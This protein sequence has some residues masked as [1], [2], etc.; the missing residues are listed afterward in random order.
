MEFD[1]IFRR[2]NTECV[3]WDEYAGQYPDLKK[4]TELLPMWVADMDFKCPQPVIDAVVERAK[5]GIYG[6][7]ATKTDDFCKAICSWTKRRYD[8]SAEPEW[9]VYTPGVIPAYTAAIQAFTNPGDGVVILQPVY[10]PFADSIRTNGREVIVSE[11]IA[12]EERYTIDFEDLEG[13][14]AL[15]KVK[16]M[17]LCNPHN[18][19]GR[20]WSKEELQRIGEACLKN[21]VLLV[22]DEIHADLIM[23]GYKQTS[24]AALSEEIRSNSIV[25]LSPSKTFNMAG[26]QVAYSLIPNPVLRADF[27]RQLTRN[28]MNG[29]NY[30]GSAALKAAYTKCDDWLDEVIN[31]IEGNIDYMQ[32]YIMENIPNIKMYR[33]EGTYL[34]WV[35]F[36]QTGLSEEEF[37]DIMLHKA[38]IA[39]DFGTW[40]GLGGNLHARFCVAC[41]RVILEDC[42]KR[43]KEAFA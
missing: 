29:I 12:G 23:K 33:P 8:V 24:A 32:N 26:L 38:R 10:Y 20:V 37:Q 1:Q 40:F 16:M 42:M 4:G 21:H 5:F 36:S 17:I 18:P 43:L 41:P 30:F 9:I 25:I 35:D 6:Y 34:I 15:P 27:T 2:E 31:Y 19:V 13:K 3:K 28:R 14:L 11:L 22:S 39:V 7:A